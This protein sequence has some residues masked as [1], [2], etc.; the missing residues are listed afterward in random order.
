MAAV[1]SS[2]L[3]AGQVGFLTWSTYPIYFTGCEL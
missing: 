3:T 1:V 2:G